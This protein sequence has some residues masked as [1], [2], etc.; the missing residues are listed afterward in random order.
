MMKEIASAIEGGITSQSELITSLSLAIIGGLLALLQQQ[1]FPKPDD[2]GQTITI[3]GMLV[4]WIAL[5]GAGAAIMLGYV[6][7]GVL[8]Q[9]APALF[10][11]NFDPA[12]S[13]LSQNF[14]AI[15]I[16]IL[17]VIS[18]AQFGAFLLSIVSGIVFIVVNGRRNV[19]DT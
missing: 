1:R 5:G 15:P 13:F 14:G 9:M 7:S 2:Q 12:K 10:N 19:G 4:F 17:P 16:W 18:T 3:R 8:V 11:H 6:L